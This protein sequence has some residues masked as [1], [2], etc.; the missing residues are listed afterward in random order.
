MRILALDTSAKSASCAVWENDVL[1]AESFINT[2]LTHSETLMPML[3]STLQNAKLQLG[4]TDYLA[5]THGPGSFTGL[6]I[7]TAAV[8]GLCAGLQRPCVGVSSLEATAYN[9]LGWHGYIVPAM[10]ARRGQVYTAA[11]LCDESG[12]RRLTDDCA[13]DAAGVLTACSDENLPVYLLGDGASLCYNTVGAD[14]RVRLAPAHLLFTRAGAVAQCAAAHIQK[15][16]AGPAR[17][18]GI[19]YIRL[20][21][22]QREL[23][24]RQ[25]SAPS[26]AD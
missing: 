22:A 5:L 6:R 7:G 4:D 16:E 14:S 23:A 20:S 11:F 18:L 25:Q 1:L 9:L 21:Q 17:D 13:A 15:G 10:D 8:K 26:G 24:Q 2:R 12:I 3:H 19:S